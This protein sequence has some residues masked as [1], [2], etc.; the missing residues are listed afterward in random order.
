DGIPEYAY[1]R[2]VGKRLPQQLR[3]LLRQFGLAQK[4]PGHVAVRPRQAL[5]IAACERVVVRRDHD[6]RQRASR[7]ERRLQAWLGSLRDEY[8]DVRSYEC[9]RVGGQR[10]QILLHAPKVHDQVLTILEAV[11]LQLVDEGLVKRG[12]KRY[13]AIGAEKADARDPV[14][15]LRARRERPRGRR[16]AE[17]R[18]EIT[19]SQLIELHSVPSPSRYA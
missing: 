2:P 16:A 14:G 3:L 1:P 9:G 15:R 8:V 6:D 5:H 12:A 13:A 19:A 18:D 17:Q 11:D 10:A 7:T 4:H